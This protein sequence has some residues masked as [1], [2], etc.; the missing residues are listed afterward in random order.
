MTNKGQ[1]EIGGILIVFILAIVGL[2]LLTASA[3]LVGDVTNTV[4][5][6]N[7]SIANDNGTTLAALTQLNGK[8]VS[9]VVVYNAT[10]DVIILSGNWTIFNNQVVNG[11]ETAL[12]N[13]TP[14]I[15]GGI[16]DGEWQISY[17]NQPTTYISSGGGRAIAGVIIIFFALAIA[18]I[19]LFPTL[20]N[21]ALELMR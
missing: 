8:F 11:V 13:T 12:I 19:T 5:V 4:D 1:I 10:G 7:A 18:I 2:V 17:T 14:E 3:Q 15:T 6:A 9:D 21:K 16:D 20:R